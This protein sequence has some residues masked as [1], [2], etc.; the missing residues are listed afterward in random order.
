ML[1]GGLMGVLLMAARAHLITVF[2]RLRVHEVTLSKIGGNFYIS[3]F[4]LCTIAFAR[5]TFFFPHWTPL[6][7]RSKSHVAIVTGGCLHP[8]HT[9]AHTQTDRRTHTHFFS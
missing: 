4:F 6:I 1:Q 3:S 8:Y 5:P 9:H 7:V 2:F